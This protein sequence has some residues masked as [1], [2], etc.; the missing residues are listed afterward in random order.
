MLK[1]SGCDRTDRK[2]SGASLQERIARL[3]A[4]Q[5][6]AAAAEPKALPPGGLSKLRSKFEVTNDAPLL[7]KGSFGLGAPT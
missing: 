4:A 1:G 3:N 5:N 7:P 6:N 2:V